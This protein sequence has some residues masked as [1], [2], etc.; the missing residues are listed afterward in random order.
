MMINGDIQKTDRFDWSISYSLAMLPFPEIIRNND[1]RPIS[2]MPMTQ[3]R[4][5]VSAAAISPP[6]IQPIPPHLARPR[7]AP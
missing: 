6:H 5:M 2:R 3:T 1:N 7:D 4:M